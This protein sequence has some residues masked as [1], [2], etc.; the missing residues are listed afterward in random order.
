MSSEQL[1]SSEELVTDQVVPQRRCL[2]SAAMAPAAQ[3]GGMPAAVSKQ[4]GMERGRSEWALEAARAAYNGAPL[5]P[6]D[7][8]G[9]FGAN[10]SAASPRKAECRDRGRVITEATA[11]VSA[12]LHFSEGGATQKNTSTALFSKL[13]ETLPVDQGPLTFLTW[14]DGS[15]YCGNVNGGALHGIGVY[16]YTD[17]S[18]YC[19]QWSHGR[20]N[21]YGLFISPNGFLYRGHFEADEQNGP[22]IFVVPQGTAFFGHFRNGRLHGLS[23]CVPRSESSQPLLGVWQDGEFHKAFPLHCR[24]AD[25]Y[26]RAAESLDLLNSAWT[27][28]PIPMP[29][30]ATIEA[31]ND[32]RQG[33]ALGGRDSQLSETAVLE[34]LCTELPSSLLQLTAAA[35]AEDALQPLIRQTKRHASASKPAMR[36]RK[37]SVLKLHRKGNVESAASSTSMATTAEVGGSSG[38]GPPPQRATTTKAQLL[39]WE[40]E[41]RK[42]PRIPHLNYNRVLGRWYARV[43]D[44]A[45]GRRIWKGYTCAVHGFFQARDMAID[46]L[47]QFSQ[48]VSPLA[49]GDAKVGE[50]AEDVPPQAT[51]AAE[52][53]K[54]Q[55]EPAESAPCVEPPDPALAEEVCSVSNATSLEERE[56]SDEAPC[57]TTAGAGPCC[58]LNASGCAASEAGSAVPVDVLGEFKPKCAANNERLAEGLR[59]GKEVLAVQRSAHWDVNTMRPLVPL[60]STSVSCEET[61]KDRSSA[62][63]SSELSFGTTSSGGTCFKT[64]KGFVHDG[65]STA[66]SR[67][68]TADCIEGS[69]NRC[70]PLQ[71]EAP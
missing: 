32:D 56:A 45:S 9:A 51:G 3:P 66:C 53:L 4:V 38:G 64:S 40:S 62:G 49:N 1:L 39:R 7:A 71:Y 55:P 26:R 44:P 46:R 30:A 48:L 19:G 18:V 37:A 15:L 5:Q 61:T 41:A 67:L 27:P 31:S 22:G 47:R 69:V 24:V 2:R 34:A 57:K 52:V 50:S 28:L 59:T 54:L 63:P 65:E 36:T 58:S 10:I 29:S 70:T 20:L 33:Q 21:G 12:G 25:F 68:T 14:E 8:N 60:A 13:A 17:S 6:H 42:L 35:A 16:R 43:R 11:S 23:C